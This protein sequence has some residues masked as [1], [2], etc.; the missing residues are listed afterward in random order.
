LFPFVAPGKVFDKRHVNDVHDLR[1]VARRE[2]LDGVGESRDEIAVAA[3]SH[4][5]GESRYVAEE[6]MR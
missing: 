5:H 1:V 4:S 2:P 3:L 6:H